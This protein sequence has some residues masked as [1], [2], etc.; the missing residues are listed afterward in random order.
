MGVTKAPKFIDTYTPI[1]FRNGEK[2]EESDKSV[3]FISYSTVSQPW[4]CERVVYRMT[5]F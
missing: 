5:N 2:I 3:A 1:D 4:H